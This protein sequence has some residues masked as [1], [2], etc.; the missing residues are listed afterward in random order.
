MVFII[1]FFK[2]IYYKKKLKKIKN[3]FFEINIK[4]NKCD[5]KDNYYYSLINEQ[6]KIIKKLFE[7]LY[8]TY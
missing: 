3:R 7:V 4:I 2:K 6:D 8:K 5:K 1:Y